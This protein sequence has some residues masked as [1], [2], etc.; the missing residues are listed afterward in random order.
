MAEIVATTN[1]VSLLGSLQDMHFFFN[2]FFNAVKEVC[3]KWLTIW[4]VAQAGNLG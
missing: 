4:I 1:G 2:F 3:I